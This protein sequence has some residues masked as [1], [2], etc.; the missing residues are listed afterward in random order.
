M[1]LFFLYSLKVAI[2]LIAFYLVYKLLLSKETFHAFNRVVLLS[3]VLI[4]VIIPLLK[5]STV[6]PI[7]IT[8]GFVSFQSLIVSTEV[9]D[10]ESAS[11][12]SLM[13]VLFIIYMIGI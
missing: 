8:E 7:S 12:L 4:S 3:V 6:K 13:Q 1:G 9:I 2:C 10:N 5:V 11:T